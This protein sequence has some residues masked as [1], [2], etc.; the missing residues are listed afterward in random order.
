MFRGGGGVKDRNR[1]TIKEIS[2]H[3]GK[4]NKNLNIHTENLLCT[5]LVT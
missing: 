2:S 1:E 5:K 4:S 3:Q